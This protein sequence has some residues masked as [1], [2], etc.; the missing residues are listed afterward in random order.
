M[1]EHL[2]QIIQKHLDDYGVRE[3][4]FARR[5]GTSPQTVNSWKLRGV[6]SFPEKSLLVGV[7]NVTRRPYSEVL[8]AVLHDTGYLP[9]EQADE[10]STNPAGGSP[11]IDFDQ[12]AA[13]HGSKA[14]STLDQEERPE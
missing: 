8:D 6:R 10:S 14:P 4:E 7:S 12:L 2:W 3:A 11:A 1:T 5:I 9:K 13:R